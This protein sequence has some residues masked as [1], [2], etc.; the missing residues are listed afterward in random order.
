[1]SDHSSAAIANAFVD[2]A[3]RPLPQMKLHKLT[4]MAHGWYLAIENEPLV[5]DAPEAWD[6]GPVF[7]KIWDRIRDYGLDSNGHIRMTNG[8]PFAA[9][10]TP[11]E[12]AV[13]N[14]VWK[15]YGKFS[16]FQLSDMTHQPDTPWTQAYFNE[17]RNAK[18]SNATIQNHYQQ[19]AMAGRVGA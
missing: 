19:L 5:V 11:S 7:R 1:M 4:Y 13:L 15:K 3:G 9:D 6:N 18:L 8:K 12:Q 16:Q 14:H 10:L 17:G 2:L